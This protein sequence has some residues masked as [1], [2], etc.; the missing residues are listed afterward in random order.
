MGSCDTEEPLCSQHLTAILAELDRSS[1]ERER[2]RL[3]EELGDYEALLRLIDRHGVGSDIPP[4]AAADSALSNG[5][6]GNNG[7]TRTAT[8]VSR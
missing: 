1:L 3:R 2:D 5:N 8:A 6:N 7:K 4:V